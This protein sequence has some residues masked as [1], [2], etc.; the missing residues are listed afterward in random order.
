M[1]LLITIREEIVCLIILIFLF[2][3]SE[4]YKIEKDNKHFFKICSYAIGHVVF[5]IITVYWVNNQYIIPYSINWLAHV[6]FYL[7]AILFTRELLLYVVHLVNFY[8]KEDFIKKMSLL[9]ILIYIICLPFLPMDFL[10]GNGTMYSYGMAAFVGYALAFLYLLAGVLLLLKNY[11]HLNIHIRRTLVPVLFIDIVAELIQII[12]PELLFTGASVTIGTVGVFFGLEDTT[13]FFQTKAMLDALTGVKNRNVYEYDFKKMKND[14]LK[15]VYDDNPIGLVF[16]DLNGLKSV[17]DF[18]GHMKGD[19]Y[20]GVVAQTLTEHLKSAKDIYRMGGDEFFAIYI[21]VPKKNIQKEIDSVTKTC[22]EISQHYPFQVEV[23]MGFAM[24]GKQF[25]SLKDVLQLA[26]HNMYE[27]KWKMKNERIILKSRSCLEYNSLGIDTSGLDTRVF[28]A[29]ASTSNRNYIYICNMKTN[30]SRWS[31][32]AVDY[33]GLPGEYMLDAG[34]IWEEYVHPEDREAYRNDIEL[35]FSGQKERHEIEY[36]ARNKEGKYVVCTC[37][38]TILKGEH[39]DSDLFVGTMINHGIIDGIDPVTGLHN[40][41]EYQ[42]LIDKILE[43]KSKG[44]IL[45]IGINH[46]SRVNVVYGNQFG[47]EV[48]RIFGSRLKDLINGKGRVFRNEGAKFAI[49]IQ[50]GQREEMIYFYEQA[51]QIAQKEIYL[52]NILVPLTLSAGC[53]IIDNLNYDKQWIKNG[54]DYALSQSKH[55]NQ[56]KL[57]FWGDGINDCDER[58]LELYY[59]LN[60]SILHDCQGYFLCYQPIVDTQNE[61]IVGIEALLRWHNE[62]FGVVSPQRFIQWLEMDPS[63][64]HLGWWI[65]EQAIKDTQHIF[66]ENPDLVMNINITA[67]QLANSHFNETLLS[68]LHKYSFPPQ[69]LCLELTERCRGLDYSLLK[70]EIHYLKQKGIYVAMDDLGTGTSSFGLLL[71]LPI[72]MIKFDMSMIQGIADKPANQLFV[73][74]IVETMNK[75][76]IKSCLE[77]VE[78]EEDY[79]F[80][81]KIQASFYQGYYFSKPVT[82]DNLITLFKMRK[83]GSTYQYINNYLMNRKK[84]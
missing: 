39:G 35:V 7:F 53:V 17:N 63:F 69:S 68:I 80:L 79:R 20:I 78:F 41:R 56:G 49:C 46:F 14:Y 61:K 5:D 66:E 40:Q 67:K 83:K 65:I 10:Q 31:K 33:F 28:E 24:S 36:R 3:A 11:N 55:E 15:G 70:D 84:E 9:I 2:L 29:F 26:D 38:G 52:E 57:I 37:Q 4:L 32:K 19:E 12:V 22:E 48:L 6:M 21:G 44:A 43:N 58:R 75:L 73:S 64:I 54:V 71:E 42:Y 47:N 59:Q 16:C 8:E 50:D 25:S 51:M 62:K 23:A 30:V 77:G 72:D 60:Q 34:T 27:N 76:S 81:K 82:I 74:N 1:N 13:V 18:Y 45:L